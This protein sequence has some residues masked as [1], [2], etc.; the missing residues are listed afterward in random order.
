MAGLLHC[1]LLH[2][3]RQIRCCP[4][5]LWSRHVYRPRQALFLWEHPDL[6]TKSVGQTGSTATL[7]TQYDSPCMYVI[8][9]GAVILVPERLNVF[10]MAVNCEWAQAGACGSCGASSRTGPVYRETFYTQALHSWARINTQPFDDPHIL[11]SNTEGE[12]TFWGRQGGVS[13]P[14]DFMIM[15]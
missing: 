12:A 13:E 6:V 7:S 2:R 9:R 14:L 11:P 4:A 10:Y 15:K 5:C 1:L 3:D 8:Y